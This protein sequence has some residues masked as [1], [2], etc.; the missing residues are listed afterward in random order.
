MLIAEENAFIKEK[1][2]QMEKHAQ[3]I[4]IAKATFVL[5]VCVKQKHRLQKLL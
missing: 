5:M 2:A 1:H 4:Q 3:S